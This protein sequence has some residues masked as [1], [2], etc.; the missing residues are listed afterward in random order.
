MNVFPVGSRVLFYDSS[1][2]IVGG[3]VESTS[4]MADGT[5]MVLVKR[6]SGGGC[7][8]VSWLVGGNVEDGEDNWDK[9]HIAKGP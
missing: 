6:D 5:Q 9:A 7:K 2:R 3:V 1:G 4:H 8:C